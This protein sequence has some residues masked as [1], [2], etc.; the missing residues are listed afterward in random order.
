MKI[1]VNQYGVMVIEDLHNEIELKTEAGEV[2]TIC[3]RDQ[4]FEFSYMGKPYF[5]KSGYVE[6]FKTGYHGGFLVEQQHEE[7]VA[8]SYF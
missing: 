8:G 6:P 4:G 3:M 1:T 7:P 2:L 5:A